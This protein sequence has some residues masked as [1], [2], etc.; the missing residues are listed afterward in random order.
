MPKIAN[1]LLVEDEDPLRMIAKDELTLQGFEVDEA[2]D[3]PYALEKMEAK[4]YDVVILDI[5]MPQMNGLDVLKTLR[6]KNLANKVIM[7]TAVGELKVA[8]DSLR[9][10]ADD[11]M[12]KPYDLKAL[13]AC[14]NR[15]LKD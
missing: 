1:I 4:R 6:E 2:D 8:Q 10:G 15:V 14:I 3:G 7:L 12:T 13:V 5:R 11:F 9:L